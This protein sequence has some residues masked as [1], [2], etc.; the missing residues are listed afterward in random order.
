MFSALLRDI[1]V[2]VGV[3]GIE[4][5]GRSLVDLAFRL[6]NHSQHEYS[7]SFPVCSLIVLGWFLCPGFRSP[8]ILF[9]R[10]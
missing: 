10:K 2:A 5:R 3:L 7:L 9:A 8:L 4:C 6:L 1:H